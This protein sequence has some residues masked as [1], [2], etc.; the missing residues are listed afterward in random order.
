MPKHEERLFVYKGE[1]IRCVDGDTVDMW[2]DLGFDTRVKQRF[3]LYGIDT[4]ETRTRDPVEKKAGLLA[5]DRIQELL[6]EGKTYP[7][8]TSKEGRGKFGRYLATIYTDEGVLDPIVDWDEA[9]IS[10]N[11]RLVREDLAVKYHGQSKEDIKEARVGQY[12][13]LKV[14]GLL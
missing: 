11:E 7:I 8:V 10:V 3:R 2:V 5:K 1:I 9:D 14:R 6:K 4:P 13:R 12:A